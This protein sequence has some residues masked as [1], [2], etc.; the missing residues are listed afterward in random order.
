MLLPGLQ[1]RFDVR[2]LLALVAAAEEYDHRLTVAP[3]VDAVSAASDSRT[4]AEAT[5]APRPAGGRGT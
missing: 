3:E 1:R 5:N 4:S 2:L